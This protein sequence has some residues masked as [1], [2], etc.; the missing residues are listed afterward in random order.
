[1]WV[2]SLCAARSSGGHEMQCGASQ[3]YE[4]EVTCDE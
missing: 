3:L 2:E 1:M 4:S